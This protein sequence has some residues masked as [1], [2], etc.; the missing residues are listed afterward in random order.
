MYLIV[1]DFLCSYLCWYLPPVYKWKNGY[2]TSK[3]RGLCAAEI[4]ESTIQGFRGTGSYEK[5]QV[6]K[7]GRSCAVFPSIG[8][9]S[10]RI[11]VEPEPTDYL[12]IP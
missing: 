10:S 1:L 4:S 2:E 9:V 6:E 5:V 12:Q 11:R 8:A 3:D 7:E